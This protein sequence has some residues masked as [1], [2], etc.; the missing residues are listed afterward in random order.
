MRLRQLAAAITLSTAA[1]CFTATAALAH[2]G[3]I[4]PDDEDHWFC[5]G[6]STSGFS[7]LRDSFVYA[8][9]NMEAYTDF[10][11]RQRADGGCDATINVQWKVDSTGG[12]QRGF[13]QCVDVND[14]KCG[15]ATIT[16]WPDVISGDGGP[17]AVNARKT[18]CHELGHSLAQTHHS[19]PYDDCMVI[20]RVDSEENR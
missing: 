3:L 16:V 2:P 6:A 18:A 14:G 4:E 12:T 10:D 11:S 8:M 15:K 13:W 19:K 5:L 7:T 1:V 17:F 9:A 20:G